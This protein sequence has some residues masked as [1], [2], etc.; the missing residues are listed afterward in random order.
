MGNQLGKSPRLNAPLQAI[1]KQLF[2]FRENSISSKMKIIGRK[3]KKGLGI[4]IVSGFTALRVHEEK[5]TIMI[6]NE[7]KYERWM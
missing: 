2:Y 3:K 1:Q 4:K 7:K 6:L 5:T